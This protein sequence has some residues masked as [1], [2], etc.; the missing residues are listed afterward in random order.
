[1]FDWTIPYCAKTEKL[2]SGLHRMKKLFI[3]EIMQLN[4]R[5]EFYYHNIKKQYPIIDASYESYAFFG[6]TLVL[7][8]CIHNKFVIVFLLLFLIF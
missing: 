8:H 6:A 1:M 2:L 7:F 3:K 5:T 4:I